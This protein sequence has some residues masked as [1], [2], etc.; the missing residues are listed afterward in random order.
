MAFY[1]ACE[2]PDRIA[3]VASVANPINDFLL[4]SCQ[5]T[6]PFSTL[7]IHGTADPFFPWSSGVPGFFPPPPETPSFWALQNNCNT[8]SIV[9]EL[10]DLVT[11]D[12]ST[13]TLI[14]YVNC[15]DSTEVLLYRVNNGGHPWPGSG[16]IYP[17]LGNTNMDINSSSEIWNFFKRNPY[18]NPSVGSIADV[19]DNV[20]KS[21]QL[22]QNYPNP[23]NPSTT[24]EFD[25][26]K[27]SDVR[28]EVYNITGQKIQT[29]LDEKMSAGNHQVEFMAGNLS[30]GVYFYK[31]EKDEFQDV[32]KMIMI[33]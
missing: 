32:K 10:P 17:P 15:D 25:L 11:T 27:S 23:F 28:I 6:R 20:A 22:F 18:P 12:N 19:D 1:L 21:F 2:L 29:L 9:T 3:S 5:V 30:S 33:K 24:I 13:V 16:F 31:I 4:N 7:L 26:P 14:E 8:D